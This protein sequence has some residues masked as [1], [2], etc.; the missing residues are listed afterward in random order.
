MSKT[1]R[2]LEQQATLK[3][4]VGIVCSHNTRNRVFVSP[5]K[6]LCRDNWSLCHQRLHE[7]WS[8]NLSTFM[9]AIPLDKRRPISYGLYTVHFEAE[10]SIRTKCNPLKAV[11][12]CWSL[13][14]DLCSLKSVWLSCT[15]FK[16]NCCDGQT[17]VGDVSTHM[18]S[19]KK[20]WS[21]ELSGL[22]I[23][24]WNSCIETWAIQVV[25]MM[26]CWTEHGWWKVMQKGITWRGKIMIMIL[27]IA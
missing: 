23:T 7:A 21:T 9:M 5:K 27:F 17:Y 22:H 16:F 18:I 12:N 26:L 1:A 24:C 6:S 19:Y 14:E 10:W 3:R 11:L 15:V 25:R 20:L 4:T 13:I 2:L 8:N